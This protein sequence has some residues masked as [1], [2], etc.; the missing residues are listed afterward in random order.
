MYGAAKDQKHPELSPIVCQALVTVISPYVQNS[1]VTQE[2]STEDTN[3]EPVKVLPPEEL[4]AAQAMFQ[5]FAP[6][7]VPLLFKQYEQQ[8]GK[9]EGTEVEPSVVAGAPVPPPMPVTS[10]QI[11]AGGI[12]EGGS[13]ERLAALLEAAT[14]YVLLCPPLTCDCDAVV[15]SQLVCVLCR[16]ASIAGASLV[17]KFATTLLSR[18]AKAQLPPSVEELQAN[19]GKSLENVRQTCILLG[20]SQALIPSVSRD[21]LSLI[22]RALKMILGNG[23]PAL[24]QTRCF[25]AVEC[26]C[27]REQSHSVVS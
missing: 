13:A 1:I 14:K 19:P 8:H 12:G 24:I 5:R 16:Y 6:K 10:S 18:L 20:L 11:P 7:F 9:W 17:Q 4:A 2:D 23:P 27:R 25:A 3:A 26:I 21:K 15:S 22:F